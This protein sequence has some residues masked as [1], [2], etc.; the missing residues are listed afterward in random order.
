[1]TGLSLYE[2]VFTTGAGAVDA[3]TLRVQLSTESLAALENI[4]VTVDNSEIEISNDAGNPIPVNGTVELGATTLAALETVNVTDNGGSLTVDAI[5]L[6][7]RDLVFATDKVDAS[8]SE[9][10]LDAATLAALETITVVATDLDIRNLVNTQDSIAIGDGANLITLEA[11]DA[12]FDGSF[13]FGIYG[14]R[15]DA[16]GSPVSA[17]GD[18]HPLVFNNAGELKVAAELTSSV[19]DDAVDS[20]NPIKVGGRAQSGPLTSVAA[21]DRYDLTGDVY[22]R[23]YVNKS[24]NIGMNT[25]AATVT[26]TAAEVLGTPLAGRQSVTIQ[27]RGNQSVFLIESAATAKTL[28]I[29]IP[30]RSSATYDIGEDVNIFLVADSGSQDVRLLELA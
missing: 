15:Q 5:N 24:A 20:G 6:D 28:G 1:M 21:G 13:G 12:A 2:I 3:D 29:E 8:G 11:S 9:V 26:T 16:A 4:T 27:N 14:I 30:A 7:I 25:V 22:R 18:A 19:A 23:T 10:S 17:T